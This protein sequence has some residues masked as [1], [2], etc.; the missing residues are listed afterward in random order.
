MRWWRVKRGGG[1]SGANELVVGETSWWRVKRVGG[2]SNK[3]VVGQTSWWRV[4]RGG[5]GSNVRGRSKEVVVGLNEDGC[6]R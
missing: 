6:H 3:V 1:G 2:G 4:K 5:G